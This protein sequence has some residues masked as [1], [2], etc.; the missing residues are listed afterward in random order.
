MLGTEHMTISEGSPV[1]QR[2]GNDDALARQRAIASWET[3]GGK[4]SPELSKPQYAAQ[5]KSEIDP[6]AARAGMIRMHLRRIEQL[7]DSLDHSPFREKDL[8][9]NAED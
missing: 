3:E 9:R 7:F 2:A 5:R 6:G 4:I 8:D 1:N